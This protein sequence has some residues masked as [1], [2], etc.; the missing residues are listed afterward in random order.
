MWQQI[1]SDNDATAS[2][3]ITGLNPP[4]APTRGDLTSFHPLPQTFEKDLDYHS[5]TLDWDLGWGTLTSATGYSDTQI[6][7]VLDGSFIFGILYP[8]LG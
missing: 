2:L 8:L 3:T 6:R 7:N 1:D 5:A 4:G